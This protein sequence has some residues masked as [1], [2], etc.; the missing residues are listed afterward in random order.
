MTRKH[1]RPQE[2]GLISKT[3]LVIGELPNSY[4]ALARRRASQS[5]YNLEI[6][7]PPMRMVIE[8]SPED[9]LLDLR[10]RWIDEEHLRQYHIGR[11]IPDILVTHKVLNN[12]Y[13]GYFA[14]ADLIIYCGDQLTPQLR[15]ILEEHTWGL[16]C[17]DTDD[18]DWLPQLE[19]V[20]TRRSVAALP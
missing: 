19:T 7:A 13:G 1:L 9:G 20:L 4:L 12:F 3:L 2:T 17:V 8:R 16:D 10:S 5:G 15:Q 11:E 6:Q 14:T 18:D